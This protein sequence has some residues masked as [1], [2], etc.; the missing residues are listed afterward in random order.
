MIEKLSIEK[1][2]EDPEGFGDKV[3]D[4]FT[5]RT[6]RN[7]FFARFGTLLLRMVAVSLLPILPT[8]RRAFT[9]SGCGWPLCGA[10]GRICGHNCSCGVQYQCPS[11]CPRQSFWSACCCQNVDTAYIMNYYDCCETGTNC[12]ACN[13]C[14]SCSGGCPQ[15]VWCGGGSLIYRCTI[16][17]NTMVICGCS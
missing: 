13:S 15:P 5:E 3:I 7:G 12:T 1:Q 6:T 14:S 10:C 2:P 16:A 11:G 17:V 8:D 4:L 9:Q